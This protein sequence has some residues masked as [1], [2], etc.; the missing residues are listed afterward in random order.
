MSLSVRGGLHEDAFPMAASSR[1]IASSQLM[2]S[3]E[4]LREEYLL[5]AGLRRASSGLVPMPAGSKEMPFASSFKGSFAQSFKDSMSTPAFVPTLGTE[6]LREEYLLG[7]SLV[8]A[9]SEIREGSK[10]MLFLSTEPLLEGV[11]N[12]RGGSKEPPGTPAFVP[13]VGCIEE[14]PAYVPL[15]LSFEEFVATRH[16]EYDSS[17]AAAYNVD[18]GQVSPQ[19][20]QI[21]PHSEGGSIEERCTA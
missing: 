1:R 7:P 15:E 18:E 11:I 13:T 14:S 20:T 10:E 8:R 5:G 4:A 3:T 19:D 2:C 21:F 16:D 12:R 9:S 6:A 17:Q